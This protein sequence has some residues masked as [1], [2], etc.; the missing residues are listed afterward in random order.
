[1]PAALPSPRVEEWA[2]G[3]LAG[4]VRPGLKDSSGSGHSPGRHCSL[5]THR[6][7]VGLVG[8]GRDFGFSFLLDTNKDKA[9]GSSL[10]P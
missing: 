2:C 8:A 3:Q 5:R 4:P 10:S 1:M 6:V 7:E 9:V